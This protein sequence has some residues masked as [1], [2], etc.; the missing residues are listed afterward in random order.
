VAAA[1]HRARK[2]LGYS[3]VN[4]AR[5]ALALGMACGG[6][7]LA[8]RQSW[9]EQARLAC[10]LAK[11]EHDLTRL[12]SLLPAGLRWCLQIASPF[13]VGAGLPSSMRWCDCCWA[14]LHPSRM[15]WHSAP[16]RARTEENGGQEGGGGTLAPTPGLS[17]ELR[18]ARQHA[19]VPLLVPFIIDFPGPPPWISPQLMKVMELQRNITHRGAPLV[20]H[21]STSSL[22]HASPAWPAIV[23]V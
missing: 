6:L 9:S 13:E 18:C 2:R 21:I 20:R 15:G 11:R 14:A 7:A 4:Y 8:L 16:A 17:G 5:V 12:V 22:A 1:A 23:V 19:H 10:L 3:Q